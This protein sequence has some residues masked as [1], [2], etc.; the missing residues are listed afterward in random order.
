MA[1]SVQV[2]LKNASFSEEYAQEHHDGGDSPENIRYEWEDEFRLKGV[3]TDVE[4]LR[5]QTYT[6]AGEMG[7]NDVFSFEIPNVMLFLV[8]SPTGDTPLVFSEVAVDEYVLDKEAQ[9]LTVVL[10]DDQVVENPIA[11]VY[12]VLNDFPKALRG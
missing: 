3:Y 10:N 4:V 6:L 12:I 2:F 7:E 5:E 9:K 11:G 1:F 8:K